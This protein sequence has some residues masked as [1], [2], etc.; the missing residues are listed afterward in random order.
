M[1]IYIS[2]PAQA[3]RLVRLWPD[4]Y[5]AEKGACPTR[6]RTY[7][8]RL[9]VTMA[10][11]TLRLGSVSNL[12]DIPDSPHQPDPG[13]K[14]PKRSFGKA[15]VVFQS[16]W[17]RQWPFLHYDEANDLAYC[18]TCVKG[19]KEKKMKAAKAEAAFVSVYVVR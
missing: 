19:F 7:P 4:Q 10:V 15:T 9:I 6:G 16:T 13:F 18:H 8:R 17:F 14:F 5:F 3:V 12:P 2:G 11:S 1:C